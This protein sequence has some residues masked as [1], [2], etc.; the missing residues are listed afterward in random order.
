MLR[1]FICMLA[2]LFLVSCAEQANDSSSSDSDL[3][4]DI[5]HGG[6][7]SAWGLEQCSACHVLSLIHNDKTIIRAMVLEKGEQSCGGCHGKNG[8][9]KARQCKIC[10]NQEDMPGKINQATHKHNFSASSNTQITDSQCISCHIASDMDGEFEI[11]RDL[12]R[13]PDENFVATPY[14]SASE[15]CMRCHNRDHQQ[16]AYPINNKA[17]YDPLIAIEEAYQYIDK[18]GESYSTNRGSYAGL[19]DGYAY[20]SRVE[21]TDCHAMHGT[22]NIKLIIDQSSKGVSKLNTEIRN[23]PYNVSVSDINYSQLCVLC[24]NMD[25]IQNQ[26]DLDT[27]NGLFG[28]HLTAGSC[29][30]CHSHGEAIQAGM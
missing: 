30:N 9:Q 17:Y 21:C 4:L 19:R 15:F 5:T 18:H 2:M 29:I 28:L 26:A 10:H 6:S 1:I 12:T 22:D 13:F 3:L 14:S 24:H 16:A 27:G 23:K 20:S 7:G 25:S 11:N 8:T